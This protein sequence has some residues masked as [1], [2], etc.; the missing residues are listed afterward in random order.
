M[1]WLFFA[2][3]LPG[4][5][6]AS[7]ADLTLTPSSGVFTNGKTFSVSIS[8]DS[9]DAN[10]NAVD[11]KLKYDNSILSVQSLSKNGS[12][13]SLFAQEPSYSQAD[14]TVT[15]SGGATSPFSGKKTVLSIT[16]KP[17]KEG[18]AKID[19]ESGSV[20]AADGKG[21]NIL[22]GKIGGTYEIKAGNTTATPPPA[23][24]QTTPQVENTVPAPDVPE[25]KSPS[26]PN[27]GAWYATSSAIFTW[28]LPPDVTAVRYGFDTKPESQPMTV[29]TPAIADRLVKKLQNGVGY[30]HVWFKNSGGWSETAH[31]KILVDMNPPEAFSVTA[32]SESPGTAKLTFSATDTVSGIDRYEIITD[33]GT[34]VKATL[35]QVANGYS[36]NG[37]AGGEHQVAIRAYDKANNFTESKATVSV[38][39][40]PPPAPTAEELAAQQP[41]KT[42]YWLSVILGMIATF[43]FGML[44]FERRTSRK[45]KRFIK[46]EADEIRTN[47]EAVFAALQDEV[48][49]AVSVLTKTPNPT[50]QDREVLDRLRE[51]IDLAEELL[52]KEVED[53]RK[54]LG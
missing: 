12:A 4:V 53:V 38:A 11:A 54:L 28:D 43:I 13:L 10:I 9:R 24:A 41:D 15:L 33:S 32:V 26:H 51:A 35:E 19:F 14:G 3:F 45:E 8:V 6:F 18:T 27:Q 34:P 25:V 21:T 40:L 2:L 42:F 23:P 36:I 47:M 52:D 29:F 46:K 20:L 17:L 39:A 7:E 49:E 22:A 1:G 30:A 37:L 50:S 5:S 31:Y 44:I 48:V 16:F